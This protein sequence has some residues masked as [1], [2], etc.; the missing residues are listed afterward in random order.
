MIT[1]RPGSFRH[2]IEMDG[3]HFTDTGRYTVKS[4][5]QLERMYPDGERTLQEYGPSVNPLK[6]RLTAGKFVDHLK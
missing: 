4:R 5:Y 1:L 2:Q 6:V 3:W